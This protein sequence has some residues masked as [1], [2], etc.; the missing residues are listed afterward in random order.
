VAPFFLDHP[1]YF[2]IRYIWQFGK[3]VGTGG[4]LFNSVAGIFPACLRHL[5]NIPATSGNKPH[6]WPRCRS[7]FA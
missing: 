5:G 1:V 3:K 2:N 4:G 6:Y 7:L